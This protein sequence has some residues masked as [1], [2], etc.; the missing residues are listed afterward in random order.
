MS[1]HLLTDDSL[2]INILFL[3]KNEMSDLR[4]EELENN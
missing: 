1:L 2:D 4:A 3:Y